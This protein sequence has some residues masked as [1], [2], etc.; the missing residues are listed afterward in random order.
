MPSIARGVADAAD[1]N[2][3]AMSGCN[4]DRD[5]GAEVLYLRKLRA[6]GPR[7]ATAPDIDQVAIKFVRWSP[8]GS[9]LELTVHSS[10]APPGR[11]P[12]RPTTRRGT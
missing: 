6:G 9:P 1:A 8:P 7:P 4:T 2:G 3:D 10:A 12:A 5:G 11:P